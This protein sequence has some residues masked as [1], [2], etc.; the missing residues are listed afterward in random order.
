MKPS[1]R[2]LMNPANL[3]LH[4]DLV[5]SHNHSTPYDAHHTNQSA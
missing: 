1:A 5:P 4:Y 2:D 3:T